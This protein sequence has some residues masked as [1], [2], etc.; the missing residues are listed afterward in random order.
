MLLVDLFGG[1]RRFLGSSGMSVFPSIIIP[2]IS[3]RISSLFL[4]RLSLGVLLRAPVSGREPVLRCLS[5]PVRPGLWVCRL[6]FLLLFLRLMCLR[7]H[8]LRELACNQV[9]EGEVKRG[10]EAGGGFL[11]V[12]SVPGCLLP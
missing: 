10:S 12:Q 5:P 1:T 11:S 8:L 7:S 2:S 6:S 9:T 3:Q 4:G